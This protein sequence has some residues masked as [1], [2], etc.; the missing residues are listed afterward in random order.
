[1]SHLEVLMER[2]SMIVQLLR[3]AETI[4][5][6]GCSPKPERDSYRVAD[7]LKRAGYRVIPVN[8]VAEEILGERVYPDLASIPADVDLDIVDVFRAPQHIP[9]VVDAVLERGAG[10]LWLQLGCSHPESEA[11]AA[12]AGLQ[13]VSD[14]CIK[15]EHRRLFGVEPDPAG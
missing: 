6:V 15:I 1:M 12:E 2:E 13:V 10:G 7:Y 5:V 3:S 9:A 14:R 8:P 4:A 11:R